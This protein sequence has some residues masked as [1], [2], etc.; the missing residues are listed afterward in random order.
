MPLP[1]QGSEQQND[2]W[3][4][5]AYKAPIARWCATNEEGWLM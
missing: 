3:R 1:T 2:W 4:D 5:S